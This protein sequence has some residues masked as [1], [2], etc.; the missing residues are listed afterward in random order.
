MSNSVGGTMILTLLY[1]SDKDRVLQ[2]VGKN[3]EVM[4]EGMKILFFLDVG[5]TSVKRRELNEN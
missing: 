1:S 5:S 3:E 2:A 4:F